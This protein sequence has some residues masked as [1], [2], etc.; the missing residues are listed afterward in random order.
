MANN[1]YVNKVIYGDT[2]V[3]D[4]SD[5]SAEAGDVVQGATFYSRSGAPTTGTLGDATQS[6][7]G[8]M[9]TTD[10]IKLDNMSG[11]TCDEYEVEIATTDWSNASPYTYTWSQSGVS[12][13]SNVIAYFKADSRAVF[14]GELEYTKISGGITFSTTTLPTGTITIIVQV[15]NEGNQCTVTEDTRE[16]FNML[17]GDY[18][19]TNRSNLYDTA[20]Q[21][22]ETISPHYFVSGAPYSSTQFDSSWNCTNFIPVEP[23]TEY[24][25]GLV[26]SVNNVIKP[27]NN[28]GYGW[29][30]YDSEK[31]Q[32]SI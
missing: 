2:T 22:D 31:M 14:I 28:A 9:S 4:I 10:K 24:T 25:V 26:P 8:L 16:A 27:W 30:A 6:T 29:F 19:I 23:D 5:T 20:I 1:Q 15:I 17:V 21:T 12:T 13:T 32:I 7:H 18:T 11:L 3:M